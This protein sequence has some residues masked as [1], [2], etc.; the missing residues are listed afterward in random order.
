MT[1]ATPRNFANKLTNKHKIIMPRQYCLKICFLKKLHLMLRVIQSVIKMHSTLI[2]P[3]IIIVYDFGLLPI[4][5][6]LAEL[7]LFFNA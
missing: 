1:Q 6:N 3:S 4:G 2:I 7:S 5:V